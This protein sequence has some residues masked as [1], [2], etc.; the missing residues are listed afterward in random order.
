MFTKTSPCIESIYF[1][2]LGERPYVCPFEGCKKAYSNS[3]D[4]F[5]H[6][7]THQEQK[8]YSCR[9]PG[10]DK[11]YTDPSS[12]RKHIKTHGHYYR[13]PEEV[14][15]TKTGN[16]E[17]VATA[18]TG[19]EIARAKAVDEAQRVAAERRGDVFGAATAAE[20]IMSSAAY[21][22]SGFAASTHNDI[23][24]STAGSSPL[25]SALTAERLL[26]LKAREDFQ[27]KAALLEAG[28]LF[29]SGLPLHPRHHPLLGLSLGYPLL[30][31]ASH[32][33][34]ANP[35]S[36]DRSPSSLLMPP[37]SHNATDKHSFMS[38]LSTGSLSPGR[39]S[40]SAQSASGTDS[41]TCGSPPLPFSRPSPYESLYASSPPHHHGSA[42]PKQS[43]FSPV[44]PSSPYSSS[45]VP[46][47]DKYS[48]PLVPSRSPL[49]SRHPRHSSPVH[50]PY[51]R[52]AF[53]NHP[54]NN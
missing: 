47:A 21:L 15:N 25:S 30:P 28:G 7:R 26:E 6:V 4:R 29:S 1:L 17:H 41:D 27:N 10:C 37:L 5:K 12:L 33:N 22:R 35:L 19:S 14:A 8:P 18:A 34:S 13:G 42:S 39:L 51:H 36:L 9:M 48:S 53:E 31:E 23:L 43:A 44:S 11:R 20:N 40:D 50:H 32:Y 16:G 38:S 2:F 52:P 3:S 46:Q 49:V 24:L 54:D 45:A